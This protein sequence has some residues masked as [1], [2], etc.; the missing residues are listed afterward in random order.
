LDKCPKCGYRRQA[1][2]SPSNPLICPACGIVYHKWLARQAPSRAGQKPPPAAGRPAFSWQSLID[3]LAQVPETVDSLVFAGR[4]L[5]W[6]GLAAW[7]FSFIAGGLDWESIG[8]SFMHAINLPFHEFGHV[9]FMPFGEFMH[10]LG[11]SLFQ[12]AWPLGLMLAFI[13][14]RQDNFGAA[15]MLWWAGQ[16][17]ID[18]S[19]Y[20][21][22]AKD[23]IL[24]LIGGASEEF[25]DWG[26]LLT[27]LG[28]VDSARKI[29][30]FS[31]GMGAIIMLCGLAWGF[32]L[33]YRQRERL[34]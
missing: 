12:V 16:S 15:V 30:Y 27:M 20:I 3:T 17:L 24:P 21:A 10:I 23:R 4:A 1:W 6:L 11:G 18:I 8:G 25:H 7:G 2:D 34:G 13:I 22:D 31:F 14:R 19:P 26:K 5:T 33:L 29:A 28:R 9:L 32:Y